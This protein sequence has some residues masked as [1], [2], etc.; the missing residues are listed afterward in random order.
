ML[1]PF[2]RLIRY[3]L[4][5]KNL[6]DALRN[7]DNSNE[8]LDAAILYLDD[9]IEGTNLHAK[10]AQGIQNSPIDLTSRG[11]L[12]MIDDCYL[13]KNGKK[14]ISTVILFEDIIIFTKKV[15][16][17]VISKEFFCWRLT[18]TFQTDSD[19]YIYKGS[20]NLSDLYIR[21]ITEELTTFQ[22]QNFTQFKKKH[23]N[24][25]VYDLEVRDAKTKQEWVKKLESLLWD[26]FEG[27][28]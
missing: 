28:N 23:D 2:Q 14:Y 13:R 9:F 10:V 8:K 6:Q 17:G 25:Y 16:F 18:K 12:L 24:K 19:T 7:E 15:S 5:L 11:K 27:K 1:T 26:Q 22:L 3:R 21:S 4:L 20:I